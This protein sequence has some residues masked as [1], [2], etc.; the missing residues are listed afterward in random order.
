MPEPTCATTRP[1]F[2]K[3]SLNWVS[4]AFSM[5]IIAI[6]GITLLQLIRDIEIEKVFAALDSLSR[7][8]ILVAAGFIV[9]SYVTLSFYDFFA[10]RAIGKGEV[11][12]RIAA[13]AGFTSYTIGHNL[14]AT[15]LTGGVIRF[16][17]YS[18][19]DLRV[20]DVAKIA[21]VT[22]LTFWLG[23]ASVL[24]FGM[25]YAPEAAS[26]VNQVPAWINRLIGLACLTAIGFYL[27]WLLPCRRVLGRSDW[28]IVLPSARLTLLQIG[29]GVIDLVLV[30]SAMYA[31]LP[32][33][34]TIDFIP[35]LVIFVFAALLGFLSHAPGSLGVIEAAML[36]GLRQFQKE[37]LL[38]S[39]LMFRFLYFVIPL[40]IAATI[41]GLREF[42]VGMKPSGDRV[43]FD[44]RRPPVP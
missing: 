14:G 18:A 44:E 3:W 1:A 11:P 17:I 26:A 41:L 34:P 29:I 12:F 31:L 43:G 35:L 22:G 21:F 33:A 32:A 38:A 15:V 10:L 9:A 6:A 40:F 36:L 5:L 39:L 27:L 25:T 24:G 37:D 16:R 23:N 8:K 30:G 7:K 20:I 28:R 2:R 19:W 13:L 4:M 42:W